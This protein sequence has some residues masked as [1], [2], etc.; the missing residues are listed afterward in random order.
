MKAIEIDD[1]TGTLADYAKGARTETLIVTRGGK[2]VV[3][4]VPVV[5]LDWEGLAAGSLPD[6]IA[7]V[8][9]S[10]GPYRKHTPLS[11]NRSR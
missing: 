5:D 6:F 7:L 9:R 10:R 1:T 4:V 8:V 11:R 3:A 2:P